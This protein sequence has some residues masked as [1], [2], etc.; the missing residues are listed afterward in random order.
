MQHEHEF[1]INT[2]VCPSDM[3][4]KIFKIYFNFKI[5]IKTV[6]SILLAIT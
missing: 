4:S 5:M 6:F 1:Q 2:N 3:L